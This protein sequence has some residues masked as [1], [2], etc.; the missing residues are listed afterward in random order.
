MVNS[1]AAAA[2]APAIVIATP[3][4]NEAKVRFDIV[5]SSFFSAAGFIILG[6]A[7]ERIYEMRSPFR[8]TRDG[9]GIVP[10]FNDRCLLA[11]ADS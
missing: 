6:V 11:A 4:I 5:S 2:D 9:F 10:F 7:A 8:F 3:A 1:S